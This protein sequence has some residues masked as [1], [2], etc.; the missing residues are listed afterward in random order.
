MT[1]IP[2]TSSPLFLKS[3]CVQL[4]SN[5]ALDHHP[6]IDEY[7]P[8]TLQWR[9]NE[10][11]SVSNHQPHDCLLNRLFRRWSRKTSNSASLAFVR[12]IHRGPVNSSHKWPVMR[13]MFPFDDVIMNTGETQSLDPFHCRFFMMTS[14]NGNIFR[15]ISPMWGEFTGCF[16]P[17]KGQ[18]R[19]ALMLP[20]IC[21]WTNGWV[22]NLELLHYY[23]GWGTRTQYS[24]SQ[25]SSTEF[26]VL[27]LDSYSWVPKS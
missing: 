8:T 13:K 18:W 17:H 3:S 5:L 6:W 24:Y 27:V 1:I 14:S 23:Q 20:L 7:G 9:H 11:D 22:N 15:V 16:P 4:T 12:G 10:R 21:A 19:G 2:Y 25:Y 26:L